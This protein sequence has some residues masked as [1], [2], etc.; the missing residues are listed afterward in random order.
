[1][2]VPIL[3]AAG[4]AC[5]LGGVPAAHANSGVFFDWPLVPGPSGYRGPFLPVVRPRAVP[6][7]PIPPP[8]AIAPV[9][10]RYGPYV[11]AVSPGER[12]ETGRIGPTAQF[13]RD[14][15]GKLLP[16]YPPR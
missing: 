14:A 2:K 1:M 5:L 13:E 10:V 3:L 8:F 12:D 11:P 9:R 6:P 7:Q 4:A 16:T 15:E